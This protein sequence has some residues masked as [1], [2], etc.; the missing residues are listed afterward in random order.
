MQS[1]RRSS[2]LESQTLQTLICNFRQD[3]TSPECEFK[4]E[5]VLG[6]AVNDVTSQNRAFSLV[7]YIVAL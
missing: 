1:R 7:Q 6:F 3:W 4:E 5:R 2:S